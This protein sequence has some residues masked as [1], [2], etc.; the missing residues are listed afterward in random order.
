[1]AREP[2]K[3]PSRVKMRMCDPSVHMPKEATVIL[4]ILLMVIATIAYS[5][6]PILLRVATRAT[7]QRTA[8]ALL[9]GA[10]TRTVGL[11]GIALYI[12]GWGLEV[13]ALR[14]LPLT[15]ARILLAG[16]LIVVL[17]LARRQLHETIRWNEVLGVGAIVGGIIAVGIVHPDRSTS[18][19][20]ILQW[21]LVMVLLVPPMF[22]P[23]LRRSAGGRITATTVA[24]SAG[25]AYA[26]SNLFTKDLSNLIGS[27]SV[28]PLMILSAGAALSS[29]VGFISELEA[30]R[31]NDAAGTVPIYR[32][33][34]ILIP[35]LSAPVLFGERWPSDMGE[36]GLL[37]FGLVLTMIGIVCVSYQPPRTPEARSITTTARSNATGSAGL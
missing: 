4:G 23:Y 3:Q 1:M 11:A 21:L 31:R 33:L 28:L 5:S 25:A 24:V 2:V 13:A 34:Q 35:I 30:L 16:G 18:E 20:T 29:I 32:G 17:I 7:P 8:A 6:A 14:D 22:M 26:L 37:L 36:L 27:S 15:L 9:R 10:L 12:L 19:P